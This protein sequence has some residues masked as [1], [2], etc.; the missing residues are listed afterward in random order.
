MKSK[1]HISGIQCY[2]IYITVPIGRKEGIVRK[3]W[4]KARL[5][6]ARQTPNPIALCLRSKGLHC[7]T[8]LALFIAAQV[9]LLG[10]LLLP[11][12][13]FLTDIPGC[14]RLHHLDISNSIQASLSQLYAMASQ[15]LHAHTWS[16]QIPLAMGEHSTAPYSHILYN[17]KVR[18]HG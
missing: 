18:M 13:S 7:S 14:W 1:S 8:L 9:F 10:L 4:T 16:Q 5:H 6:P 12:C 2:R 11:V 17:F 3:Y 15:G